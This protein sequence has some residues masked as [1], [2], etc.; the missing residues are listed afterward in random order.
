MFSDLAK[1][2]ILIDDHDRIILCA[3]YFIQDDCVV[4]HKVVQKEGRIFMG[5]AIS[6]EWVASGTDY[7]K[8]VVDYLAKHKLPKALFYW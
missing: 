6:H 2:G 5:A 7:E 8:L 3:E 1:W 4:L